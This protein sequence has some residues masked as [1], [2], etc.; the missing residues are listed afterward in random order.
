MNENY[1]MPTIVVE[2]VA[3]DFEQRYQAADLLERVVGDDAALEDLVSHYVALRAARQR[4]ERGAS[5]GSAL[6]LV[7][8]GACF[9]AEGG[10]SDD[11]LRKYVAEYQRAVSANENN[12]APPS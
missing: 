3:L 7:V 10:L 4:E 5:T 12:S 8:L 11:H 9:W 1:G 2:R 6:W